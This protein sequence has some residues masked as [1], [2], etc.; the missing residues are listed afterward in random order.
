M[1]LALTLPIAGCAVGP[2]YKPP[3]VHVDPN[4][5]E[6]NQTTSANPATQRSQ[7]N[8]RGEPIVEWWTTLGDAELNALV[9]R[10]AAENLDVQRAASRVRQ[11]RQDVVIAGGRLYPQVNAAGGYASARGSGNVSAPLGSSNG[12][13]SGGAS[14]GGG[15]KSSA[16]RFR[17][18]AN[19]SGGGSSGGG[20]SGGSGSSS[21]S[22]PGS[23]SG[24]SFGPPVNG[25]PQSPFGSGGLPGVQ[26]ELYQV[27]LDAT[28]EIDVFGGIRRGIE[29]AAADL[30]ASVEDRRE[31][32]IT[33]LAEVANDYLQL[34]GLQ[35]RIA[36]ARANLVSQQE[37]LDLTRQRY[38]AGV[39]TELDVT[40]QQT[41]VAET[42]A[43]IPPLE[44]QARMMIH[45]ISVLAGREPLALSRE[46][47]DNAPLPH[48]PVD[49]PV[50]L[51][52]DLLARRPDIRRAEKQIQAANARI[53]VA[54]ADLYP[55]FSITGQAGFDS[56]HV[57]DL[58]HW[59][60]RYFILS[61]GVS[62]NVFDAGRIRANIQATTEQRQQLML[63]YQQAVLTALRE[64]EDALVTYST[65]Q[66]RHAS[67]E[68]AEKSARASVDIARDQYKQ[69]V[70]DFLSV[71]DTQREL[72]NAQDQRVQS[73]QTIATDLVAL[74]KA[75]GGGWEI[76]AA[77]EL[78]VAPTN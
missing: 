2:E 16:S 19:S 61:P 65:E 64:S 9:S 77:R 48:I 7:T 21:G 25:G 36:I 13:S 18:L 42:E 37:T 27:G 53:G 31:V 35:Q 72:L 68:Q 57:T 62:W 12:A 11:A 46:L 43:L 6:L 45:A 50:G 60:S 73:E 15:G 17:T 41:Q 66:A 40:R 20:S 74:Y 67:L 3:V 38:K 23:S 44:A 58:F 78:E 4:F 70:I 39:T 5:G 59:D 14:A 54:T 52:G 56:S 49:V 33:L 24:G 55:K 76:D 30:S 75:L 29:A 51:P 47:Q 63:A 10:A 34:R 69:G 1:L 71:L 28:W 22:S 26:T 32:L 8:A